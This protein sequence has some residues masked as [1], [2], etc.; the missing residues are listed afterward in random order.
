MGNSIHN[1]EKI[2]SPLT[3]QWNW[4][5][6]SHHI[7]KSTYNGFKTEILRDVTIKLL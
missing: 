2:A 3:E 7:L 6:I 5:L 4:V 1:V